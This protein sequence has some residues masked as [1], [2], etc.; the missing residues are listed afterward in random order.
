MILVIFSDFSTAGNNGIYIYIYLSRKTKKKYMVQ[1]WN[2][3]LPNCIFRKWELYCNTG[4]CI[5]VRNLGL[6]ES[7]L[8]Y[9]GS[10][11][12]LRGLA[13]WLYRNTAGVYCS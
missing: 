4:F 2:G 11:C 10:Y 9:T 5:A 12:R 1:I 3:L 7:V 8:Q 13:G 6:A